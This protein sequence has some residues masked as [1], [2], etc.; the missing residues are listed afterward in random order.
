[1]ASQ[2]IQ[3]PATNPAP[4]E[5]TKKDIA[6]LLSTL[7]SIAWKCYALGLHL[8][9]DDS[10][11]RNIMKNNSLCED[12]LREII[13][14]RLRQESP[15]TWHD[16]VRALR[17]VFES[18]L[19]SEIENKYIHHL[20]AQACTVSHGNSSLTPPLQMFI[21]QVATNYDE[22][23]TKLVKWPPKPSAVYINLSC[24]NRESIS[25]MSKEYT[26]ITEAM[27]H[28]GN[29]DAINPTKRPI[30]F[31]EIARGIS[32]PSTSSQAS[33]ERR[34]ILI[35]G[36]PGV[37]KSTFAQ[38]FCKRWKRGEIAQQYQL[39]WLLRLRDNRIRKANSLKDLI[40]H[41]SKGERR[42]VAK[43][44]VHSH[45]FHAM[46]IL[47]GFDELPD[48]CRND[49]SIFFQLISGDLLP[50][51][52]VLVTSRPWATE[53]IRCNYENRIYQHIEIL[54]FASHQITEYIERA[55]P[56]DKVSN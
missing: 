54:G 13:S 37:G 44:L 39:V 30:E 34:V 47:E 45:N 53:R 6:L 49:Q 22:V 35:E 33:K 11:I 23:D 25:G 19:A 15:L 51:A 8:G 46:I 1:M 52:T 10:Q 56:E 41:L 50:L 18:V 7:N 55:V 28:D 26:E 20:P 14:E 16:I 40:I 38:E 2:S 17:A 21:K 24:I 27:V 5:L 32:I 36:A 43:E 31:N 29:V 12:Q 42:V 9:V 4:Q 3:P 48:N